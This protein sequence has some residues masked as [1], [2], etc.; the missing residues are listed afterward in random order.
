MD[1]ARLVERA[2]RVYF[3]WRDAQ[4]LGIGTDE[5]IIRAA[6]RRVERASFGHSIL[7]ICNDA[8]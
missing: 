5:T 8:E 1:G 4:P 6:S 7:A 2:E 3:Y